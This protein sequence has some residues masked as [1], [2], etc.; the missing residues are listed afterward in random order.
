M[1]YLTENGLHLPGDFAV[2]GFGNIDAC[3]YVTPT[4]STV[5]QPSRETGIV[6]ADVLVQMMEKPIICS[7]QVR[8]KTDLVIRD[9]SGS[10]LTI[11][12]P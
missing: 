6:A 7:Q 10:L 2:I 8:L 5:S 12:E 3:Q 4:L 11:S 9:S 1:R